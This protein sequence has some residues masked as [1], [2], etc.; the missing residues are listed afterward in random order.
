MRPSDVL[1]DSEKAD[2]KAKLQA[3][4]EPAQ[5]ATDSL[6]EETLS[7]NPNG[8]NGAMTTGSVASRMNPV[9]LI[10]RRNPLTR[11]F[12]LFEPQ[13]MENPGWR[14]GPKF[15]WLKALFEAIARLIDETLSVAREQHK[16]TVRLA[17]Y[18]AV[19]EEEHAKAIVYLREEMNRKYRDNY[20]HLRRLRLEIDLLVAFD[21]REIVDVPE[22]YIP[23][24]TEVRPKPATPK[25]K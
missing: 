24:T 2:L 15:R 3:L 23:A 4:Q 1:N 10:E 18:V 19:M 8:C 6:I 14:F 16:N 21:K 17:E 5:Q 25:A 7:R 20:H 22:R 13:N 12:T 9:D 11:A